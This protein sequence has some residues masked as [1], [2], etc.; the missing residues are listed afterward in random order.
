M[1]E[2]Y[3]RPRMKQVWSDDSKYSKWLLVELAACEAWTEEGVV[4]KEDM[5]LL[6]EAT[7]DLDRLHEN[8]Q[9]TRHEM[10][11]FLSAV[12]DGIGPEGRWLHLGLTSSDVWDTATSLQ[13]VE[14]AALL[15]KEIDGLS[16]ALS[17]K[18]LEHKK[19][20]M[21]GRTHGVHAEPITFGL[22]LAL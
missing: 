20:M 7:V 9:E 22:K 5:A 18:A 3:A 12:T 2:R 8:L 1:I 14:A 13:M 16:R 21:M 15:E 4:P 19:T 17:E 6:R 10:T 11:A